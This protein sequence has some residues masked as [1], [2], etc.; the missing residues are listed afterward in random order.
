MFFILKSNIIQHNIPETLRLQQ[1]VCFSYPFKGSAHSFS[2]QTT[3]WKPHFT[4]LIKH[5]DCKCFLSLF[6]FYN[7][8]QPTTKMKLKAY[9]PIKNAEQQGKKNNQETST[10]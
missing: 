4:E 2:L 10:A 1:H 3:A 8:S 9:S 6:P 7:H 5:V